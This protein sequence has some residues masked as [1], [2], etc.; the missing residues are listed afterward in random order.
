VLKTTAIPEFGE[1]RSFLDINTLFSENKTVPFIQCDKN[2]RATHFTV[3]V[4]K[5]AV[6]PIWAEILPVS[7]E[8]ADSIGLTKKLVILKND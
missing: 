6:V 1:W 2:E 4:T 5:T 8:K 3:Y 7:S